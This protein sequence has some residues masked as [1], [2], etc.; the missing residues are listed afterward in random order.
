MSNISRAKPETVVKWL[1]VI[2]LGTVVA[3]GIIFTAAIARQIL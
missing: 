1:G 2:A 3:L